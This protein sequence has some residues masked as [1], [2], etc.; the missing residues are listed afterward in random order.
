MSRGVDIGSES[1]GVRR[2]GLM[3]REWMK[4]ERLKQASKMK[5]VGIR[6]R[7]QRHA[8]KT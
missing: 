7:N 2:L 3:W 4:M 8:F 1:L 5:L 6:Q